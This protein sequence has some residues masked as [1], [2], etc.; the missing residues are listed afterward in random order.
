MY[1]LSPDKTPAM[2]TNYNAYIFPNSEND[3]QGIDC[4]FVGVMFNDTVS[5]ERRGLF[6]DVLSSFSFLMQQQNQQKGT[7]LSTD[8][9][10]IDEEKENEEISTTE[11]ISQ[12]LINGAKFITRGVSTTTEYASKYLNIGGDKIK[13]QIKQ[14]ET[15]SKV[16]PTVQKCVEGVRYGSNVTVR[17]SSFLV[18]KLGV[19]A[20]K[21]AKTVAPYIKSGS[22]KLLTQTGI[23]KSNENANQY[24]ENVCTVATSSVVGFSIVY[25]S[26][27]NAAKSLAKSVAQQ[28][29]QVVTHKYGN[30]AGKMTE[31]VMYSAG[32]VALSA[33]NLRN[34]KITKTI[35]KATAKE[36]IKSFSNQNGDEIKVVKEVK[37]L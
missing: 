2:K 36:T 9:K 12:N 24:L 4:K 17:V 1:P 32:N 21:T 23:V 26:L 15:A 11:Y 8:N 30:D 37:K 22:S 6:E 27:E 14:N 25:E 18:E 31:N 34:L 7:Q 33:N 16:D 5:E 35:A 13:T 10:M 28:S 20:S 3:E 29:V 19:L